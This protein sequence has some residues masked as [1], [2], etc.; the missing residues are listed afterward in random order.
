MTIAAPLGEGRWR[1]LARQALARLLRSYG[2]A[3][4]DLCED[5]VQEAL[6]QAHQQWPTHFPDD[7]LA[8]LTAT[9]RRRYADHARSDARRRHRETRAAVLHPPVTPEAVQSDDSLLVL[10][11][12][13][14]PDLPRSGQVALTLRAVAGLTTAQIANV[15]QVPERTIAQRITRAKRRVSELGRPLPPPEHAGERV[16]AVLDVLYVMFTE[17]HHTTAGAPPRDA[18]LA[19]E[20]I[21]LTRLLLRSVPESTEVTGLLALMLLT[22]ARHP[23][24]VGED[25]RLV[26]LDEQDRSVWDQELIGEGLELVEHAAPGAEPGPYLLQACIAALHAEAPDTEKTDW[27]EILALYRLLEFVTG[28][29]NPTITLNRIVAQ[30]MAGGYDIALAQI[31]A[32][33]ADHPG[34]PRLDAVRAHLLEEA[35]RPGD[36]ANAYRRAIATTVNLA[37]QRHLRHRLRRLSGANE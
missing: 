36:A 29:R 33:E 5:A 13:C 23:A 17:A 11:L 20:A 15:Y 3:Q 7:P 12:C 10:Q 2:S 24:R 34:L 31:D 28:H 22:E 27:H 21:H 37:E 30:A 4:F 26:P 9:A 14:H 35:N 32:L 18:D 19:A 1:E 6:L 16:T 25:G 8:W